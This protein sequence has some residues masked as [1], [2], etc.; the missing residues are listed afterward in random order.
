MVETDSDLRKKLE[1]LEAARMSAESD[2]RGAILRAQAT[3]A[4]EFVMA[5]LG[6]AGF[7]SARQS[8]ERIL[9]AITRVNGD[10]LSSLPVSALMQLHEA[11]GHALSALGRLTRYQPT[12]D[13]EASKRREAIETVWEVEGELYSE[14]SKHP[15]LLTPSAPNAEEAATHA[16]KRAAAV[17]QASEMAGQARARAEAASAAAEEAAHA[18]KEAA[19]ISGAVRH[20]AH[21]S[22]QANVHRWLAI[23]WLIATACLFAATF[24]IVAGRLAASNVEGWTDLAL[25]GRIFGISLLVAATVAAVRS[26]RSEMHNY[27][28]NRARSNALLTFHAFREGAFDDVTKDQVLVYA[29]AAAFSPQP[30][31]HAPKGTES[32]GLL[33]LTE[34][35][36][37]IRGAPE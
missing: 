18:A 19:G 29:A 1:N 30:S 8:I 7:E 23:A 21:F 9:A 31:G 37:R 35:V 33:D 22:K 15:Q 24:W 2:L 20:A 36:R 4:D 26:F 10:D 25:G 5:G 6:P 27:V 32:G 12:Q 17:A 16:A 13:T 14:I 3:D 34:A 11:V 28:V